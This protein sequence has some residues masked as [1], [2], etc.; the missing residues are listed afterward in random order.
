MYHSV[1]PNQTEMKDINSQKTNLN[2]FRTD[3]DD[4]PE[5]KEA[6][7][8]STKT[9]D[10]QI[11]VKVFQARQLVG[12]NI[13]P[14]CLIKCSGISKSTNTMRSTNTPF[15][16]E[17]FFFNFVS[18]QNKLFNESIVFEVHDSLGFA[19]SELIGSFKLDI[20][21]I[22]DEPEHSIK[23]KWLLLSDLEDPLAGAKGYLNVSINVLGPGD[24]VPMTASADKDHDI[25][26]NILTLPGVSLRNATFTIRV[27]QAEDL[28]KSLFIFL[29][30]L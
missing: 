7:I 12:N 15:W 2:S 11:R 8:R 26:S 6:K 9:Q 10:F 21:F 27:Y 16:D 29:L 1:Q 4:I 13:N 25:E 20:G 18:T 3:L 24:E 28:P 23:S 5:I 17:V 30:E 14:K 22:Y 19:R